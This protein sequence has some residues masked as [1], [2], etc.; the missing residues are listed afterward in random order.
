MWPKL[1]EGKLNRLHLRN[2]EN[3]ETISELNWTQSFFLFCRGKKNGV[4]S[5]VPKK[6][7]PRTAESKTTTN[8]EVEQRDVNY[9][10]VN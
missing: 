5:T 8:A 7:A 10:K 9:V 3:E 4:H 6:E 1:R 2:E